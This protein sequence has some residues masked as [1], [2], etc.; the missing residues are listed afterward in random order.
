MHSFGKDWLNQCDLDGWKQLDFGALRGG[1][2]D[3]DSCP[4]PCT[5]TFTP[6][7]GEGDPG[8]QLWLYIGLNDTPSHTS[9]GFGNNL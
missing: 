2:T 9:L 7:H 5:G 3:G 4:C 6:W 8:A 1:I